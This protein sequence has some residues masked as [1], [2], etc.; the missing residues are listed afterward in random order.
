MVCWLVMDITLAWVS[1]SDP[2]GSPRR[3]GGEV[4]VPCH[5][6]T[7]VLLQQCTENH[8]C[9]FKGTECRPP[10]IV[11]AMMVTVSICSGLWHLLSLFPGL[12]IST[13]KLDKLLPPG[14]GRRK[15]M[16]PEVKRTAPGHTAGCVS[17]QVSRC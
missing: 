10:A 13:Y 9:Q 15:W 5:S 3:E 2:R 14:F 4:C 1:C 7:E 12:S 17:M 11:T 8:L 16:F 6:G